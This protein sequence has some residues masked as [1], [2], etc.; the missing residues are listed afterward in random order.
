MAAPPQYR[1]PITT[2][3]LA[4]GQ[5]KRMGGDKGLQVLHGRALIAW[6]KEAVAGQS[7]EVLLSANDKHEVYAGLGCR[8][9]ADETPGWAGPLAG[10]Q[11]VMRKAHHELVMSVPCDTPFL[12]ADLI[13]RLYAALGDAEAAVALV[14]GRRQ[15]AIT[16]YRKVVLNKLDAYLAAGG[17][18]V[19]DWL[20]LLDLREVEFENEAAFANINSQEEL[21]R[22]NE[23]APEKAA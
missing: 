8:V 7:D 10:L 16:L 4:G 12:P 20:S 11:A 9:I 14:A 2:V 6:V 21:A 3:I 5:G 1:P 13:G 23:R 15:P 19:N 18:K 17:R 22:A